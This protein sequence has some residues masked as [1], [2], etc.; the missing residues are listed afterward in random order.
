MN[1]YDI[2]MLRGDLRVSAR[3]GWSGQDPFRDGVEENRKGGRGG[4]IRLDDGHK[5]EVKTKKP[6]APGI[7]SEATLPHA[8]ESRISGDAGRPGFIPS[9]KVATCDWGDETTGWFLTIDD[10]GEDVVGHRYACRPIP[11][12]P[13]D[14]PTGSGQ[15]PMCAS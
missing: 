2:W 3:C 9:L 13:T 11:E 7:C 10:G 1:G 15:R 4:S 5:G 8:W 6:V 14:Q 12:T